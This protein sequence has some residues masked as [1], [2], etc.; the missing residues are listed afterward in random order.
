MKKTNKQEGNNILKSELIAKY[1]GFIKTQPEEVTKEDEKVTSAI[2]RQ[3]NYISENLPSISEM[4]ALLRRYKDD[5]EKE[6]VEPDV[7]YYEGS[8]SGKHPKHRKKSGEELIN[9]QII[10]VNGSIAEAVIIQTI[11]TILAEHGIKNIIVKLNDIGD[12]DCLNAYYRE[13]TNYYRKNINELNNHCRQLFKEGVHELVTR[14]KNQCTTIH[15]NAPK[16]M[17][18]LDEESRK[19]FSEVLE[20]LETLDIQYEVDHSILGD[21]NYSTHTVFEVMDKETERIFSSGGRYDSL[22]R[23]SGLRKDIPS[24]GALLNLPN[25]QVVSSKIIKKFDKAN[26]FFLQIGYMAKLKSLLVIEEFR[27]K[28][29]PVIH[30]LYRDRLSSQISSAKKSSSE[31]F[32]IMGQKEALA[33]ELIVRDRESKSQKIVKFK[34]LFEYIKSL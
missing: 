11:K 16:P 26:F 23:K 29:I 25:P 24:V 17:D 13:A 3:K 6:M 20:F 5:K 27:N 9:L 33:D 28:N 12:R 14:G 22:A 19:R 2:S 7:I 31:H 10:N 8:A 32:I 30:K 1:F 18:F 15:E 4:Y 34:D 21:P